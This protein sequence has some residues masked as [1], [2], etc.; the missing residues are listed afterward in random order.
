M[1]CEG[2]LLVFLALN[3]PAC[4]K[5]QSTN[6]SCFVGQALLGEWWALVNEVR[7]AA[8]VAV[9][10]DNIGL[11]TPERQTGRGAHGETQQGAPA[12]LLD[13]VEQDAFLPG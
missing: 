8:A 5:Y 7:P 11:P 2:N 12:S 9:D 13:D 6:P 4:F 1:L 3:I 10:V